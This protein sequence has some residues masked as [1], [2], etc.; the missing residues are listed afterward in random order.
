MKR[1]LKEGHQKLLKVNCVYRKD[2][3]FC[4]PR[5]YK[6]QLTE[7]L[8]IVS[9]TDEGPKDPFLLWCLAYLIINNE[10]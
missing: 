7:P 5:Q 2:R 4:F 6:S 8:L 9:V 10:K 3:M 1:K